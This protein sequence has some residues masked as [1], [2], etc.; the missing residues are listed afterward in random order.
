MDLIQKKSEAQKSGYWSM[1]N[2]KFG[3][4]LKGYYM[5]SFTFEL[6]QGQLNPA[7]MVKVW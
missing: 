6:I 5:L 2:L 1:P 4:N 7:C 3:V